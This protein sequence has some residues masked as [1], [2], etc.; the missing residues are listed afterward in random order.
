MN[1]YEPHEHDEQ[2]NESHSV[3]YVAIASCHAQ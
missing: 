1:Y 2:S 3:S